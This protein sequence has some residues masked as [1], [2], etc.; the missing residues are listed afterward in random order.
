MKKLAVGGAFAAAVVLAL[1]LS[2]AS[3]ATSKA[4]VVQA[5]LNGYQET[6]SVSTRGFGTFEATIDDEADTITYELTYA[7]L[8]GV[9][10]AAH[11]HLGQR[12][13]AGGVSVFLCGGG[14]KGPCP[15]AGTVTGVIDRLDVIGPATQGIEPTE[16][17]ELVAAIRV[18]HTYANVHSS[19]Q[20]TDPPIRGFP[21]GE[22][23]GQIH[24][25]DQREFDFPPD[26]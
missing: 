6:P 9:V 10:T 14:D 1:A 8:Q 4:T 25:K 7:G 23:R 2:V 13:Q 15:Q 24:N 17:E 5:D 3:D 26:F 22:I 16:I 11:I 12:R 20:P 19:N 18:G 21:G